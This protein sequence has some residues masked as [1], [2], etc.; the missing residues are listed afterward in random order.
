M[1]SKT[2]GFTL[3]ELLVVIAI[4]GVLASVVLVSLNSARSKARD[5]AR[6][7][8]IREI[9]NALELYASDH[10]GQYPNISVT[11][12]ESDPT[13]YASLQVALAP[14]MPNIPTAPNSTGDNGSSDC[15]GWGTR[16]VVGSTLT[17]YKVVAHLP[18]NPAAMS[19]AVWDPRR[20]GGSSDTTVDGNA[21]WAIAVYTS[22]M[23]G[24]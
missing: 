11:I 3:I 18:E 16:Y 6:L 10:N 9:A 1:H 12:C 7:A 24:W 17:D 4:I 23:A 21:P 5:A 2:R 19:K 8:Q 20:D 13:H 22:G 15:G 14:Y